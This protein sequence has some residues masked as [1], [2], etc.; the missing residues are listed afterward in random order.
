MLNQ[1]VGRGRI[2]IAVII[3][4][5]IRTGRKWENKNEIKYIFKSIFNSQLFF[6]VFVTVH[7]DW[8]LTVLCVCGTRRKRLTI[9]I[10]PSGEVQ[11]SR[12]WVLCQ[13]IDFPSNAYNAVVIAMSFDVRF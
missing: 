5:M 11:R 2:V 3:I 10:F 1:K 7:T 9:S 6:P 8:W 12:K 4:V 13:N